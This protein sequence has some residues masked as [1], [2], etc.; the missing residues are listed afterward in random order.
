MPQQQYPNRPQQRQSGGSHSSKE[1][2]APSVPLNEELLN[3]IDFKDGINLDPS[4]FWEVAE[5][6]ATNIGD[7]PGSDKYDKKSQ[8]R[9]FYDEVLVYKSRIGND[10]QVFQQNLPFIK[11]IYAKVAYSKGRGILSPKFD[12]FMKKSLMQIKT[13]DQFKA[14]ALFFEAFM[15][16]YRGTNQGRKE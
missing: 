1:T 15:G 3:R 11:M 10:T 9:K 5:N 14:F 8:V 7:H 2:P 13:L 4:L 16:F 12:A 6:L